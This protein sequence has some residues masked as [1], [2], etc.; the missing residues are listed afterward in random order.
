MMLN[1]GCGGHRAPDP[2]VN[3]DR[4]LGSPVR[5]DGNR[6]FPCHPDVIADVRSLPFEDGSASAIYAGHVLEHIE[7]DEVHLALEEF[8]RVL[9]PGGK[10]AIV[11]PDM[12]RAVGEFEEFAVCIWPGLVG[13]WSN[14]AGAPHQ[15]R[16]TAVNTWKLIVPVFPHAREVPVGDLDSFWP[17][18]SRDGWQFAF[19]AQKEGST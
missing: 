15:Y 8:R 7:Y 17:A 5:E 6:S 18:P 14:W 10:L 4:G 13:E 2:W 1:V 9:E 19:L 3:I 11:G 16:P 12:D